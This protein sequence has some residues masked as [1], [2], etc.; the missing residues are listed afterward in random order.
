M[1]VVVDKKDL[2]EKLDRD[3]MFS[4][5]YYKREELP[6]KIDFYNRET[7]ELIASV[8]GK[9]VE[10]YKMLS[11]LNS[12]SLIFNLD[13]E[14]RDFKKKMLLRKAIAYQ[15][16]EAIRDYKPFDPMPHV[17]AIYIIEKEYFQFVEEPEVHNVRKKKRIQK[18]L[19]KNT[20]L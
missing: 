2:L 9:D 13:L 19:Q 20:S 16:I 11:V 8:N 5:I 18:K 1:K 7:N 17:K 10:A 15:R 14:Y 12:P 3:N 6:D 4:F